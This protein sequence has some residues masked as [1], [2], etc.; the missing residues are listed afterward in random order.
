MVRDP[1]R[2]FSMITV[3]LA[4]L[5]LGAAGAAA[6][7]VSTMESGNAQARANYDQALS[8]ADAGMQQFSIW[9]QPDRIAQNVD[10]IGSRAADSDASFIWLPGSDLNGDG[11]NDIESRYR[12]W[13]LG[14]G[15]MEHSGRVVI[16]G[17]AIRNGI[18]TSSAT[19][20]VIVQQR[21]PP[22][23]NS[24]AGSNAGGTNSDLA[25]GCV[26]SNAGPA[27]VN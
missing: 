22:A 9:A 15:P 20:Q 19:L 3:L 6:I 2:G 8:A 18:V 5:L 4:L 13:G 24:Q 14:D 16:Q 7:T 26:E 21:C 1:S 17:Q 11:V 12:A 10:L 27:L 25:G 23:G